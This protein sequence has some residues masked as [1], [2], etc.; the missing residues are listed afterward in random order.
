VLAVVEFASA[1]GVMCFD[2]NLNALQTTVI[3]DSARS[4][5]A[6]AFTTI[7]YGIRPLGAVAG[8]LLGTHLGLRETLVLGAVGGTLSVLWLLPSPIPGVRRLED[9]AVPTGVR[10]DRVGGHAASV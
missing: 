2:V 10:G 4:R 1:L 3:P 5:V 9:L 7:N 6:G 8:G